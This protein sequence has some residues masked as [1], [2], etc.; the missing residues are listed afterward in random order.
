MKKN[1]MIQ[2]FINALIEDNFVVVPDLLVD[3]FVKA[4]DQVKIKVNGKEQPLLYF[5]GACLLPKES[6]EYPLGGQGFYVDTF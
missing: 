5:G 2:A 4:A 1:A 3:D 6:E